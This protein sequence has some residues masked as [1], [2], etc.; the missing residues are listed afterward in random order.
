M[1]PKISIIEVTARGDYPIVGRPDLHLWEPTLQTLDK[2]KFREFEYIVVDLFYDERKDYFKDHNYG[3]RIK[4]VPGYPNIWHEKGVVQICHQF[5]TGIIHADGELLLFIADSNMFH[6]YLLQNLWEHY[7]TD[8]KFVSLGFGAD[9]SYADKSLQDMSRVD[10]VPT[11]WYRFLGYEGKLH[12]D[13]RYNKLFEQHPDKNMAI[14][15]SEWYYGISTCELEAALKINGF[16]EAFDGDGAL[17]D[18]DFGNRLHM[19]G[20]VGKLA[21]YRD[22]YVIEAYAGTGWHK[23]MVRPEIKCNYGLLL[24]NKRRGRYHV[25]EPLSEMDVDYIINNLCTKEC[26]VRD[27]CQTLPHRGP[28]FNKNELENFVHWKKHGATYKVDLRLERQMRKENRDY[29]EGIFVNV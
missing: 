22:S 26:G 6:P 19:I 21:M 11:E 23:K 25:N 14:I 9:V 24:F 2:Q 27:K 4:H 15:D 13:H 3:L 7:I 16:D 18:I 1:E 28:F 29:H 17:N 12:I 5:N 10:I 8:G 20:Y